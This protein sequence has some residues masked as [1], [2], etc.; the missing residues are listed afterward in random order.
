MAGVQAS[1]TTDTQEIRR[2]ASLLLETGQV[3][4]IRAFGRGTTSGY[5]D[6]ADKLAIAAA[7]LSGKVPAVYFTLNPVAPDLLARSANRVKD[8]V[9]STTSDTQVV[10]HLWLPIDFDP[11]RP[12]DISSTDEEHQQARAKAIEAKEWLR[13]SGWPNPILADSGN[14]CHALYRVELPN[15]QDA[16]NLLRDCLNALA[17]Q[18]D[19]E[20]VAVDTGNFNAAHI[21][22]VYGTL[23][24]KG[25]SIPER[26][27]RLSRIPEA[28]DSVEVVPLPL[29]QSLAR[30]VPKE[31][32][33]PSY[34]PYGGQGEPFV[35]EKWLVQYQIPIRHH[36]GWNGGDRWVLE[37]CPWNPEHTDKSAFIVRFASGAI[38]A[39]CHHNSCQGK[40]WPELRE[41]MEPG[42]KNQRDYCTSAPGQNGHNSNGT[43]SPAS[44]N[45]DNPAAPIPPNEQPAVLSVFT[46]NDV[47]TK[48]VFWTWPK[49]IPTGKLTVW[50]G[51]PGL[52]KT[53]IGLDVAARV[54]LGG[55]WPDGGRAPK[56]NILIISAEDD[57]EDTVK[58]RLE[59]LGADLSRVIGVNI[60]L[61]QGDKEILL[62]LSDHLRQLEEA[63]TEHQAI[64][65]IIDPI[66]AFCGKVNTYRTSDVRA[67]LAPLSKVANRTGCAILSIMHLNKR[68]GEG[69]SI[70]RIS[71]SLAFT[72]ASRSVFVMGKHPEDANRRVLAPVKCNLAA[73]P[74]SL[75]FRFT[76]DGIPSW[77]GEVDVKAEDILA[78][79]VREETGARDDAK[80]FL[81]DLLG[82]GEVPAKQGL[83]EAREC[84]VSE[85]TLKRAIK[86]MGIDVARLG[87]R[88]KKGGG[89]WVWRLPQ[90]SKD[91]E[92]QPSSKSGGI[93][94]SSALGI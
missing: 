71:D 85:R 42:Y 72:A 41:V 46:A 55:P 23:A 24:C 19:D 89:Q 84:G 15:N 27:H 64:L 17:F 93:L 83:A 81:T 63:I 75:A 82:D 32:P 28:T 47:L 68:S 37:R 31:P 67:V 8:W 1:T 77:E 26:P 13:L 59:S 44:A 50:G 48:E 29:L 40:G 73:E 76:H 80:Q 30:R 12:S 51:D 88:G 56:G 11:R 91:L 57:W 66:L 16:A 35:L 3:Y 70:Y 10:K 25:D 7:G 9:K 87:E 52:G 69:T 34:R 90:D 54:S 22:K 4:E 5:F 14:G 94:N 45:G 49:R 92:C 2:A 53:Y 6:D 61:T 20:S 60:T 79:A 78:P 86:E 36:G 62:S 74:P 33:A 38:A 21:W 65:C 18:F 58:P 43:Y 39:G